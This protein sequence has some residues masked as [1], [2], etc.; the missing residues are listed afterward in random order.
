MI[1]RL[2]FFTCCGLK[3]LPSTVL[4]KKKMYSQVLGL[5][6]DVDVLLMAATAA[7]LPDD[8]DCD[9]RGEFSLTET[10]LG[11]LL[12]KTG[13]LLGVDVA[14]LQLEFNMELLLLFNVVLVAL[15]AVGLT[16]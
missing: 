5:E 3:R 6:E 14:L 11:V 12:I 1:I 13:L 10:L 7:K 15:T 8:E 9:S 2:V 4:D 16:G